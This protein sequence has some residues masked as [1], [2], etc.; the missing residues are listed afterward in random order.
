MRCRNKIGESR[1]VRSGEPDG[2]EF[3]AECMVSQF[4]QSE[5]PNNVRRLLHSRC[6]HDKSGGTASP[7]ERYTR[8]CSQTP[9]EPPLH[10]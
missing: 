5:S 7:A 2:D 10:H 3:F 9:W 4:Q 6:H 1:Y 8:D